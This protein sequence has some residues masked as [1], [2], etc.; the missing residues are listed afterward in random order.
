MLGTL[1]SPNSSMKLI[2]L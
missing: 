2:S 1:S